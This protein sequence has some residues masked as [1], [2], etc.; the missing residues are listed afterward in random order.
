MDVYE[1]AEA[2]TAPGFVFMNTPG[3]DPVSLA[4]LA[5]GGCN[6]IA[7]TTGRGSAI[8]FP[9]VPV[10]KIATNS[11]TYRRMSDNM[12][13][14]AGRS[15]MAKPPR[16]WA[17][18]SSTCCWRVASGGAPANRWATGN[19][20]PGASVLV[21]VDLLG[22]SQQFAGFLFKI[23]LHRDDHIQLLLRAVAVSFGQQRLSQI[24]AGPFSP[25]RSRPR[26]Q[27]AQL[28]DSAG[29]VV[30]E[31]Q[32][33]SEVESSRSEIRLGSGHRAQSHMAPA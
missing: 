32:T 4:G 19:S 33:D 11:A 18:K 5:A 7:F 25:G 13:V 1:Y 28:L 22:L 12:D 9:T 20:C 26:D 23:P 15:P 16:K 3:Y 31:Q 14:N 27:P 6:L 2:V 10:I 17:A 30:G 29:A 8:G 24:E 21:L